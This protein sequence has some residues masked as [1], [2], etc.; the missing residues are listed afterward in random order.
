MCYTIQKF[1]L[2]G[3]ICFTLTEKT[4]SG[5]VLIIQ[6]IVSGSVVTTEYLPTTKG[7]R[8]HREKL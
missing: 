6:K 7:T 4:E 1:I 5:G 8:E 3:N 2:I